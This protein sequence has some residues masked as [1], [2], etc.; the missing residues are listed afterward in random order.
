MKVNIDGLRRSATA[1]MNKLAETL[2]TILTDLHEGE[3]E[4]VVD[5]YNEAAMMI[6]LLN[7]VYDDSTDDLNDLS[8]EIE[9]KRLGD[10]A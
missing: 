8:G 2:E 5:A 10:D 4:E 3:V 9:V 7:L 1:R 6:G